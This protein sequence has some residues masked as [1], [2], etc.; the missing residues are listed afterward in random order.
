MLVMLWRVLPIF[1]RVLAGMGVGLSGTGGMLMKAGSAIGWIVLAIVGIAVL[2]V[3][4]IALLMRT[5]RREAVKQRLGNMIPAVRALTKKISASRVAS[6]LS[7][8]LSGGFPTQEALEMTAAVLEDPEAARKVDEVRKSMD[9]GNAMADALTQ[10]NLFGELE[11]RMI[12]MGAAAGREDQVLAK[13]ADLY[14]EQTEESIARLVGI[15]EPTLVVLLSVVVGAV[16]LSVML[17][18]AGILSS[19]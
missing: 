11:N 9:E 13:I 16:L 14:E 5:S 8:M 3:V 19:L 4:V 10:T 6:V 15:I 18:M 7:M 17:P 12:R 2:A 1:R